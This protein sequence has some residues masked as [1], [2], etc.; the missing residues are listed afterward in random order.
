M[1]Q[2]DLLFKLQA[3]KN[4]FDEVADLIIQPD[5]LA[6]QKRYAALNKEYK[7]LEKIVE[8]YLL[9]KS[10]VDLIEEANAVIESES[11]K[12]MVEMAK[13]E[14]YAAMELLPTMEDGIKLLLIP[15]DPEDDKPA[16]VELRAGTGGDEAA[17]FVEDVFRMYSMYFKIKGWQMEILNASEGGTK[18]FKE[19]I[20]EV[21]GDFV[22]GTL[23]FES[24]V[25]RVQRVPETESQGRVHTSAITV[26]VLPEAEEVDI[27]INPADLE[28]QTAR[29]SGAG[30]QNV[31][32]VETKVQL[33][34]K[35]SG[36]VIVCQEARSQ[37]ANKE[38]A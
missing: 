29:S 18:G 36:I 22:F 35:P 26:A 28:F 7:D 25:H 12:E 31:N 14:K 38:R 33:T 8:A 11:D 13:E 5:V 24:G 21:K 16:I 37:L 4:R 27:T 34:H 2:T 20:L 1:A 19:L 32:K 17:I 10:K 6:D 15:K 9:Y 3:I 30:G 23:K